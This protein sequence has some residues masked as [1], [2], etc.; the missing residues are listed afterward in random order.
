MAVLLGIAPA[1]TD[2]LSESYFERAARALDEHQVSP[3]HACVSCGAAWPCGPALGAAFVLE[4][5]AA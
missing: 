3:G 4:M 5:H 1:G 2:C